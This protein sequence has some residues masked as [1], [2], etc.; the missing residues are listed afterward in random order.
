[1]FPPA[2]SSGYSFEAAI[3]PELDQTPLFNSINFGVTP[4]LQEGQAVNGT[5]L[6]VSI[7]TL[8]CPSEII[9]VISVGWTTYAG[10]KGPPRGV[11][12]YRGAFPFPPDSPIGTQGFQDGTSNTIGVSEWL[13]GFGGVW[14]GG[15]AGDVFAISEGFAPL[16]VACMNYEPSSPNL[17]RISKGSNWLDGEYAHSLYNHVLSVNDNSCTNSGSIQDGIY[18][19]D[20]RHPGGANTLS[21]D[22]AVHFERST[23]ELR[24]W[25]SLGTRSGGEVIDGGS[26]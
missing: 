14:G 11:F 26:F 25:R 15:T 2:T 9:P 6:H 18:S 12:P 13:L 17:G 8:I 7:E 5:V 24:V 16:D 19:A 22:G 23:I 20:S 4:F 3:L 10:N 21:M 1:M